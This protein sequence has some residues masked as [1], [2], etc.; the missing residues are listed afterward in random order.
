MKTL[1][2]SVFKD[3]SNIV[4]YRGESIENL[5]APEDNGITSGSPHLRRAVSEM[6]YQY[7]QTPTI[8]P[9]IDKSLSEAEGESTFHFHIKF[10]AVLSMFTITLLI[11]N[12]Y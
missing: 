2:H 3:V 6:G 4:V 11:C 9:D 1:N 8:P 12:Y 7:G 10:I 5:A